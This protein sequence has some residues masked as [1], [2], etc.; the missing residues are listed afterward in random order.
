MSDSIDNPEVETPVV[1]APAEVTIGKPVEVA[2]IEE[3]ELVATQPE[4]AATG[5]KFFF[6]HVG[7]IK[8]N[9]KGDIYH[10]KNHHAF[11]TDPALVARLTE[12]SQ[13]PSNQIFITE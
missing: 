11:I 9:D 6:A 10:V 7:V 1:E 3:A 8:L 13:I 2:D 12:L 4:L 5:K